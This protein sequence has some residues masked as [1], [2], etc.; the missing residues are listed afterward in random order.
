M[1]IRNNASIAYR[2]STFLIHIEISIIRP[3]RPVAVQCA[4]TIDDLADRWRCE[5]LRPLRVSWDLYIISQKLAAS[6]S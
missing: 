3:G 2:Q 6:S 5:R 4:C 1:C